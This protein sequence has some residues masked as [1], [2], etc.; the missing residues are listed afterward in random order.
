MSKRRPQNRFY[1]FAALFIFNVAAYAAETPDVS[2]RKNNKITNFESYIS[3]N[4]KAF[5]PVA[6]AW[7]DHFASYCYVSIPYL[8]AR[9]P[10]PAD[11]SFNP[12]TYQEIYMGVRKDWYYNTLTHLIHLV[13]PELKLKKLDPIELFE[14][15]RY[16]QQSK[17]P[18]DKSE[19][20]LRQLELSMYLFSH[21]IPFKDKF[22][23]L[24]Q[25]DDREIQQKI[26]TD[27]LFLKG[28][29]EGKIIKIG[30]LPK[31]ELEKSFKKLEASKEFHGF[32]QALRDEYWLDI[33]TKPLVKMD[34]GKGII[35][36]MVGDLWEFGLFQVYPNFEN[37]KPAGTRISGFL[38]PIEMKDAPHATI[39]VNVTLYDLE[40][41]KLKTI[42][43]IAV[44]PK[45]EIDFPIIDLTFARL[46]AV[47]VNVDWDTMGDKEKMTRLEMQRRKEMEAKK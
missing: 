11:F 47:A 4:K 22:L 23:S 20:G 14:A 13:A 30:E 38:K 3:E 2:E 41:N 6:K 21:V 28:F 1:V 26:M 36:C 29:R 19:E 35:K 43:A 18:I 45:F 15:Y 24:G 46:G 39:A 10:M 7:D 33:K 12:E 44:S 5:E 17:L 27:A 31:E 40:K 8:K 25:A 34:P 32:A 16:Q 37:E 42:P 9:L